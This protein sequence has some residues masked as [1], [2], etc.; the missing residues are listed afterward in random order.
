MIITLMCLLVEVTIIIYANTIKSPQN[1]IPPIKIL[2][3]SSKI[4]HKIHRAN[5][6]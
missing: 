6:I 1:H 4:V 2:K 5:N 3:T